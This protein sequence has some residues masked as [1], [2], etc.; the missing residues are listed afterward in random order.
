MNPATGKP[1]D[2]RAVYVVFKE[3]CYDDE[4]HPEN[5]WANRARLAR[6]ALTEDMRVKRYNWAAW[7]LAHLH[8]CT[9]YFI[10][11]VWTDICNS[12]LPRTEKKAEEQA[13]AR[14][15]GRAWM[16]DGCQDDDNN[17]R[18]DKRALKMNSWDTVRVW[19]APVLMR[20]KL[21]VE[22]L[23]ENFAG[24]HPDGAAPLVDAG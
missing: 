17:L 18:A 7:M 13:L 20:G 11:L 3:R 6:K 8:T 23:P 2:K 19:W 14:K 4:D 16:S 1:V 22:V 12:I 5:T 24:D 21:H 9:W 10:N 15:N